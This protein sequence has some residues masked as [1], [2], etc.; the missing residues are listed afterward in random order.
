MAKKI[1]FIIAQEGFRD[2]ELFVPKHICEAA[3]IKTIVASLT[4]N[5]AHGKLGAKIKP[6]IAVKDAKIDDYDLCTV[7][8]GPGSPTL[9]ENPEILEKLRAFQA[10]GKKLAAICYAPTVLAKAGLLQ[11]KRITA[12]QDDFSIPILKAGGA[13][14]SAEAVVR[15]GDL[16]TAA[17][18]FAAEEFG[19]TLVAILTERKHVAV[20]KTPL[21]SPQPLKA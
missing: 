8:G 9:A 10:H 12:Y 19:K 16:I 14:L 21:P 18:P 2:E 13:I 4:T 20:S 17:G 15:D 5:E 11:G 6:D 3:G 1:L 7:I